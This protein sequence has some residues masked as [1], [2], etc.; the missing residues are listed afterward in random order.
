MLIFFEGSNFKTNNTT[1]CF[2]G[3]RQIVYLRCFLKS[4]NQY[5]I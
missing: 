2:A 3:V 1:G 5:T 4:E